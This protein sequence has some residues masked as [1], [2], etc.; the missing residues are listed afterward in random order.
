MPS[1]WASARSAD[2]LLIGECRDALLNPDGIAAAWGATERSVGNPPFPG[3][4]MMR[5]A[6]GSQELEA[7]R[8]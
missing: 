1:S 8:L 6:M 7:S 3:D 4:K 5:G 2:Q